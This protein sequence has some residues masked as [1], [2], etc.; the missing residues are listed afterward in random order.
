MLRHLP[1]TLPL[2]YHLPFS[3]TTTTTTLLHTIPMAL[4]H[5]HIFLYLS[6]ISS[7]RRKERIWFMEEE[8]AGHFCLGG[9]LCM[10]LWRIYTVDFGR[11]PSLLP[12]YTTI[13]TL[14]FWPFC[15]TLPFFCTLSAHTPFCTCWRGAQHRPAPSC[16]EMGQWVRGQWQCLEWLAYSG[17]RL[18]LH[19]L[20]P[21]K[22]TLLAC[23]SL[24]HAFGTGMTWP[25]CG[26]TF[27]YLEHACMG[28]RKK[29]ENLF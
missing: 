26:E 5:L 19:S 9:T 13:I 25:L 29:K 24:P 16:L 27:C 18:T 2:D 22:H 7:R 15:S 17:K 10:L 21:G 11:R 6:S 28:R 1:A 20:L 14:S 23:C 3:P 8:E 4:R 12:P